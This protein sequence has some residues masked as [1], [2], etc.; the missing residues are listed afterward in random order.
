M[1]VITTF[2]LLLESPIDFLFKSLEP[3]E[4]LLIR[5]CLLLE[6]VL[7]LNSCRLHRGLFSH[8]TFLFHLKVSDGVLQVADRLVEEIASVVLVSD[9]CLELGQFVVELISFRILRSHLGLQFLNLRITVILQPLLIFL[10]LDEL[11]IE[12][13]NLFLL[14]GKDILMVPLE[15]EIVHLGVALITHTIHG[16]IFSG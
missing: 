11:V 7:K 8:Q 3:F 12:H 2:L 14:G 10:Q 4:L 6:L 5:N 15:S 1:R 16:V 13:L 9:L